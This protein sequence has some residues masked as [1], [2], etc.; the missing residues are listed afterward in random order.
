[1]RAESM[2]EQGDIFWI[3]RLTP[4]C[5]PQVFMPKSHNWYFL[6]LQP[7]PE[8]NLKAI[9]ATISMQANLQC[10]IFA[11]WKIFFFKNYSSA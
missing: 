10:K 3:I 8:M 6:E 7:V 4:N 5:I 2:H 11:F 1:M 9:C